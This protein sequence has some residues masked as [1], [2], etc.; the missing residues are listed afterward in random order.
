MQKGDADVSQSTDASIVDLLA[1]DSHLK[2][3]VTE[4][5]SVVRM[6]VN[7][8]QAPLDRKEVRQA[9]MYALDRE[10]IAKTITK[11]PAIVNGVA[12]VPPERPG[13]TLTSRSTRTI[14]RR[15]SRCSMARRCRSICWPIRPL[16]SRS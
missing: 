14:P 5:L 1:G 12:I 13:S 15:R 8:E 3:D 6:A 11:G 10:Q 9:I 4:P 2:V 16:E 7:T